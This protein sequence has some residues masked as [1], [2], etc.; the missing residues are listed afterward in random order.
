MSF[1][2]DTDQHKSVD[3]LKEDIEELLFIIRKYEFVCEKEG[4]GIAN[5][6]VC[7]NCNE[8]AL[9]E[10]CCHGCALDEKYYCD[11]CSGVDW[12]EECRN[13]Y[14]NFCRCMCYDAAG[15]KK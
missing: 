8:F 9:E 14:C 5:V 1:W 2:Y 4:I 11:G 15:N 10:K 6:V 3:E 7:E 12:C 13:E